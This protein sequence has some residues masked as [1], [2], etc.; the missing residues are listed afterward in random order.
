MKVDRRLAR[1]LEALHLQG[2][3]GTLHFS[4]TSKSS[5]SQIIASEMAVVSGKA[6]PPGCSLS[7]LSSLPSASERR[8]APA[9][10]AEMWCGER[11]PSA[12]TIAASSAAAV[13]LFSRSTLCASARRPSSSKALANRSVSASR[14]AARYRL[15]SAKERLGERRRRPPLPP[16]APP[17]ASPLQHQ[18]PLYVKPRSPRISA[19]HS[20]GSAKLACRL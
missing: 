11:P 14:T 8:L 20:S 10:K 18:F 13:A 17:P 9:Q 1:A 3:M 5:S 12:A 6:A 16:L 2:R 15:R 4:S 19:S 7:R